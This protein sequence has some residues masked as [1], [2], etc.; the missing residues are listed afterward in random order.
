MSRRRAV[1][2]GDAWREKCEVER[3]QP[4]KENR[5]LITALDQEVDRQRLSVSAR[6]N[7]AVTRLSILVAAVGVTIGALV[8][9]GT[10]EGGLAIAALGFA[11]IAALLG[12]VG[13]W[14][15][16]GSENGIEDL[17]DE[18]W[19]MDEDE[20]RYVLVHRKTEVLKDDEKLLRY[21]SQITRFGFLT[22]SISIAMMALHLVLA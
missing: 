7:A 17:R 5:A 10:V 13:L 19:Q 4:Y 3:L 22:L 16:L 2:K 15:R 12:V 1:E 14:P 20:A 6:S 9:S 21:R 11:V 8:N 18:L